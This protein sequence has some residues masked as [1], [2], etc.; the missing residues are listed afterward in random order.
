MEPAQQ[1]LREQPDLQ[2]EIA[3]IET[4]GLE[5]SSG[6]AAELTFPR[7]AAV[8]D[9]AYCDEQ[10]VGP[11]NAIS[12]FFHRRECINNGLK[13]QALLGIGEKDPSGA[14]GPAAPKVAGLIFRKGWTLFA[15]KAA[16][17]G[18]QSLD[19][20]IRVVGRPNI[21]V[22]SQHVDELTL[23]ARK[24]GGEGIRAT[25][26]LQMIASRDVP[27]KTS[28]EAVEALFY[29]HTRASEAALRAILMADLKHP[30]IQSCIVDLIGHD[31]SGRRRL[32]KT[33]AE[34]SPHT[35]I[36]VKASALFT[37]RLAQ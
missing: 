9:Q 16:G 10:P 8:F 12:R 13:A 15:R 2:P 22:S 1:W 24:H 32:L 5:P 3:D 26:A 31:G 30:N 23:F 17:E 37:K 34:Y 29:L 11:T 25:R 20:L 7:L 6:E 4:A 14:A 36:R 19:E 21:T 27:Q 28:Y 35:I 18:T 33:A